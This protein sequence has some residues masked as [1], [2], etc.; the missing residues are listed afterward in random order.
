MDDMEL[1]TLEDLT[2]GVADDL[3]TAVGLAG[4]AVLVEPAKLVRLVAAGFFNASAETEARGRVALDTEGG[5]F[6]ATEPVGDAAEL[7][8][9]VG[10]AFVDA[11]KDVFTV[12]RVIV[13]VWTTEA[14][15]TE[16]AGVTEGL[17]DVDDAKGGFE[18]PVVDAGAV[19]FLRGCAVAVAEEAG[20]ALL[21]ATGFTEPAPKVPELM[22]FSTRVGMRNCRKTR[23]QFTHLLHCG[24]RRPTICLL[25]C[26]DGHGS[27]LCRCLFR[28]EYPFHCCLI[29]WYL[30]CLK[31]QCL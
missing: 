15:L 7:R 28:V 2:G 17:V 19:T 11:A 1:A 25:S 8:V 4:T 23:Q 24:C 22:I 6:E 5:L 16:V 29:H 18:V 12:G 20:A 10:F 13:F 30:V 26:I 14:L 9:P 31:V 3:E 21:V 27:L